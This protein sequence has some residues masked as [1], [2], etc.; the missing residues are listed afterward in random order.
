[1]I[2]EILQE[3]AKCRDAMLPAI[4]MTDGTHTE[5]DVLAA[6]CTGKMKLWRNGS[7]GCITEFIQYP[8]MKT[9]NVFIAGGDL[10]EI[11]PLQKEIEN[12]GRKNGCHRACLLAVREGWTR[13]LGEGVKTG[14]TY[15]YKDL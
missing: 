9:I 13:V 11:A 1:M 4:A 2:W 8:Q 5:D 10:T 3:W 15:A 7:S 6:L 12:Y 14:G